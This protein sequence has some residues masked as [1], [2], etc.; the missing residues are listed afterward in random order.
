MNDFND[1]K[2]DINPQGVINVYW[3][4]FENSGNVHDFLKY[5]YA[6]GAI[7]AGID[8][9]SFQTGRPQ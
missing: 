6:E 7:N 4:A 1:N 5:K 8:T 2:N 9:S 3:S